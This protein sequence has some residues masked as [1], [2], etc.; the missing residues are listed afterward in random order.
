MARKDA[1][2]LERGIRVGTLLGALT[3][4]GIALFVL[5]YL[6][7]THFS[8]CLL[9]NLLVL[10][11][12][13]LPGAALGVLLAH[14][15]NRLKYPVLIRPENETA[16]LTA[17]WVFVLLNI[18]GHFVS[19]FRLLGVPYSRYPSIETFYGML[20][21]CIGKALLVIVAAAVISSLV[22]VIA[23]QVRPRRRPRH[24]RGVRWGWWAALAIWP[25][26]ALVV[27]VHNLTKLPRS[28]DTPL[29]KVT[30]EVNPVILVA[31]DGATWEVIDPLLEQGKM[32]HLEA[33][34]ERGYRAPLRTIRPG[35]SALIWPEIFSG[36]P[37]SQHGVLNF[38]AYKLPFIRSEFIPPARRTGLGLL[39][40]VLSRLHLADERPTGALDRRV[41]SVWELA[42]EAGLTVGVMDGH[43]TYP[44]RE[45]EGY[46][47]S[48]HAY[49]RLRVALAEDKPDLV[50]RGAYDT[51]PPAL[52]PGLVEDFERTSSPSAELLRQMAAVDAAD[53]ERL[54]ETGSPVRGQPLSYLRTAL[55][56]DS[57]RLGAGRR[58]YGQYQPVFSFYFLSGLDRVE[59][60][61]WRYREAKKFFLVPED[62]KRKFGKTIDAYYCWLDD[63]LAGL[64]EDATDRANI[65]L[66]SDHGHGPV[67]L[68][69]RG[70]S[71][72]HLDGPEGIL[73]M[74]GPQIRPASAPDLPPPHVRDIAP[75]LL[76]LLGLPVAGNLPG[77]ILT[78]AIDPE[79]LRRSPAERIERYGPPASV[80]V[81]ADD[82][83]VDE[84]VIERLRAFGYL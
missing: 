7:W 10:V 9:L 62:Q 15:V 14:L 8:D 34:I 66:L 75:T 68:G 76:Y 45:V 18:V 41:S 13:T 35:L 77:R 63:Q 78:E 2:T 44:A 16:L 83:E 31:W 74:A 11:V 29:L 20:L 28:F 82:T 50:Q 54:P 37:A 61:L 60:Y 32:P 67:F 33:L 24:R 55:A 52:L 80:P 30:G 48:H 40:R 3:G 22:Y 53:I 59:H 36:L 72:D 5:D 65:V 6:Q 4:E 43:T 46:L 39:V 71:G 73:V 21:W 79:L 49:P 17:M 19:R 25:V 84:E 69:S 70:K 23:K 12:Y 26:L 27:W 57:F 64:V 38:T 81:P 42:S 58:L 1:Q 56:M 47:V 51:F